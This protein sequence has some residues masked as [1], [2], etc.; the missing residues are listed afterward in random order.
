MKRH[1]VIVVLK[2]DHSDIDV[3]QFSK[4]ARSFIDE[5]CKELEAAGG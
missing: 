1:A 2:V 3:V 4:V 5:V